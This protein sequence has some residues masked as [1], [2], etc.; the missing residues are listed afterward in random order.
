MQRRVVQDPML[1]FSTIDD[2]LVAMDAATETYMPRR[3]HLNF[4]VIDADF[5]GRTLLVRTLMRV[6]PQAAI[7]EAQD[8]ATA[9]SLVDERT[10][11]AIIAHRAIGADPETLVRGIREHERGVPILAVSGLDRS[12]EV[13]AAGA[14]D[15]LNYDEWL[16]VGTVVSEMLAQRCPE[17]A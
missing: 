9:L 6:F 13:L 3:S 11:D 8:Y 14:T 5:D 2:S 10:F 15:F 16:R 17:N 7:V 12:K 4:L 1:L